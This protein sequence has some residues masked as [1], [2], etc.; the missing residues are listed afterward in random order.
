MTPENAG[1]HL[2]LTVVG[3]VVDEYAGRALGLSRPEITFVSSYSDEAKSV[4]IYI[5][6]VAMTD[7]PEQD[8]LAETVVWCL[9][10]GAGAR[11]DAAAIIE[12][13]SRDVPAR[14]L[15]HDR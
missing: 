4:E 15:R 1:K 5:A 13:I 12:P 8:L 2:R 9:R 14:N 11:D 10:E 3:A 7:V 6:V